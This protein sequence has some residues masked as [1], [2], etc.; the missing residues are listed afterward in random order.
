MT[1]PGEL[2][3]LAARITSAGPTVGPV[4]LVVIDGPAGSG[5][6][7]TAEALA[8]LLDGAPVVHADDLYE[9]WPVVPGAADRGAAFA[10]LAERV[11]AWLLDPWSRGVVATHPVWDWAAAR[12]AERERTVPPE[13]VVLIEGVGAAAR[14]MRAR[15]V[16]SVWVVHPD[17]EERLR[18]VLDRDGDQ[19]AEPMRAWQTDEERW[20]D[21][22]GTATGC[23]VR[24]E[25]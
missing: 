24:L 14:P 8:A 19:V 15:A 23:T 18:R 20:F 16:A 17:R 5:K 13:P 9:G 3:L 22:D 10:D 21:A 7:A 25:T 4:R 2:D 12:W 6:T 1:A 11:S